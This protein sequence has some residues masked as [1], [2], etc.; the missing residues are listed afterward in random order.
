MKVHFGKILAAI[1][2]CLVASAVGFAQAGAACKLVIHVDGFHNDKG[3]LGATIF[4][5]ADGWPEKTENAFRHGPFPITGNTGVATFD[6]PA[7]D[8]GVAVI[9]DINGNKKLDRNFLGIPTE[10]FG[11]A[12]NP[13]VNLSAPP[14]SAAIVHVTCPVTETTIHLI[15]K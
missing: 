6:L 12:N 2:L 14:Y 10:G 5:S 15:Y 9:D 1:A 11:F 13:K 7:G 4:K 3:N 8:Y